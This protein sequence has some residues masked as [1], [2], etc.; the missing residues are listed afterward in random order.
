M[1]IEKIL[2]TENFS[3]ALEHLLKKRDTCGIDGMF[4]SE[5]PSW[6]SLNQERLIQSIRNN[7]YEPGVV[8]LLEVLNYKG[9]IRPIARISSVDRLLLRAIHQ[10]L[11]NEAIPLYSASSYA[12]CSN[13]GL[14]DAVKKIKTFADSGMKYVVE[15]DIENCFGNISHQRMETV[16]DEF[17]CDSS[18]TELIKKFLR[19]RVTSDFEISIPEIGLLQGSP[20]S[21][22]LCNLYFCELDRFLENRGLSFIRFADDIKIFTDDYVDALRCYQEI[23]NYIHQTLLLPIS[24]SKSGVFPIY[25]R[26][27]LGYEM[28][29]TEQGAE[30]VKYNRL[31]QN[32]VKRWRASALE[33]QGDTYYITGDGILTKRDYTLLFENEN[34]KQY[35][36]ANVTDSLCIYS[37]ITFGSEFF[38]AANEFSLSVSMF[39]K[40]GRYLGC[41]VPA[42]LDKPAHT[43]LN[44]AAAY[45]DSEKRLNIARQMT[46]SAIH[47]IRA[48]LRYYEKR[49]PCEEF[50]QAIEAA[51]ACMEATNEVGSV[52]ELMM[53][54]ARA[55][56]LYFSQFN[57]ILPDEDFTYV[58]RTKRP[59]KD[60]IN[61]LISFGN[62]LLY[63]TVATEIHKT[64]LDIRISFVHS[65]ER[66]AQNLNLDVADYLKPVITD[67][68]IFTLINK[69]MLHEREDFDE[70]DERVYLNGKGKSIFLKAYE[71]KLNTVL[72]IE[73]HRM[74]YRSLISH[75]LAKLVRHI[76]QGEKYK[77]F[78]YI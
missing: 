70:S 27:Y 50:E 14:L 34:K 25:S 8:E 9:K 62:T 74:T 48:N 56:N 13:R 19:Q 75:E 35:I 45:R 40:Y 16:L 43:L 66:R 4:L 2:S 59:P 5:L 71:E 38:S 36:P 76:N 69:E 18:L 26:I 1:I 23:S 77:P 12:F 51:G 20:I 24:E 55:R 67:R 57:N 64:T 7:T 28:R 44:Q 31:K 54:E 22:V 10:I 61:A 32:H 6:F 49:R 37:N 72:T 30:I 47:N 65:A 15:L 68:L 52:Q 11:S 29:R 17:F 42:S 39:D 63:Q 73:G 58:K 78:R 53:V 46:L 3:T 41:F 60:A 21:P 33:K